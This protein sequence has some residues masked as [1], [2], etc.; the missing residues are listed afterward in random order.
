MYGAMVVPARRLTQQ[1]RRPSLPSQREMAAL[2]CPRSRELAGTF[3]INGFEQEEAGDRI[4]PCPFS[5]SLG[6]KAE[7]KAPTLVTRSGFRVFSPLADR[8]VWLRR[9]LLGG[10]PHTQ[11]QPT[12]TGTYR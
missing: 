1:L 9:E 10:C 7:K 2:S 3:E 11:L 6:E 5:K 8:G 12:G 4:A